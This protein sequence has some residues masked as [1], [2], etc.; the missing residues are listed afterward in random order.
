M[1]KLTRRTF[2]TTTSAGLAAALFAKPSQM[3][4]AAA[5]NNI[6][7]GFQTYPIREML[8]K[9]IP[10]T[11][12]IMADMGY[13][14]VEM[15]YPK[16]YEKIGFAPF[17][18]FKGSEIKKM[19]GDAGLSCPS[20]HFGFG[21]M[22][23]DAK[24]DEAIA[25]SKDLGLKQIVLSTFWLPK[26]A[27]LN[28]YLV[29]ADKLN[30]AAEKVKAAGLQTGFHNHSFEFVMLDG[31][32]IY[33]ALMQR[34]DANLVKMQFQTEVINLGFKASDYFKKFPGRFFSAHL[35]DWTGDKKAV[36]IGQG[37]IDWNE[38]FPAAKTAGVETYFVEM[39][40]ETYK[41]SAAYI[42]SRS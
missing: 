21:D 41:P 34:F 12:K 28:D 18:P 20:C 33:D 13:K 10:G 26:T 1:S 5:A 42:T 6:S 8:G 19:F 40:F 9:D 32:L 14:L 35:S 37:V 15:C 3:F 4:A 30:K 25:F 31:Q 36:P 38:F 23:D 39:A 17:V 11:L 2:I 22:T 24:L 29:A 7:L 16:G 27:T